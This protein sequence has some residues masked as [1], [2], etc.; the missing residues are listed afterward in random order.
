MK[1]KYE[2]V[3]IMLDY[4]NEKIVTLA[5]LTPHWWLEKY[6]YGTDCDIAKWLREMH[7]DGN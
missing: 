3:E 4:E 6:L 5:E 1:G 2:S 7:D